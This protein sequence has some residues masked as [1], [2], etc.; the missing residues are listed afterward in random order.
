MVGGGLI[1]LVFVPKTDAPDIT[2]F[3]PQLAVISHFY[4]PLWGASGQGQG[5]LQTQRRAV[6]RAFITSEF[7]VSLLAAGTLL[8]RG[9]VN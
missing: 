3:L 9:I 4:T 7:S 6:L 5:R 1:R 8:P 2:V